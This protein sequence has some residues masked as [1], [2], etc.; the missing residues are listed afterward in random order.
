MMR[1]ALFPALALLAGLAACQQDR[2]LYVDQAYV[3][4][5]ANPAAP[6]AAYFT[7]HGGARDV[8]LRDVT[9]DAAVRAEMHDSRMDKGVM[10]MAP[11]DEVAVP[12]GKTVS[13]APGGRHLMLWSINPAVAQT[14]K[15]TLTF[16][17]SN[18]D[19]ILVDAAIQKAGA[20]MADH[21]GH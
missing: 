21:G 12:A 18:G 20:P 10:K 7:V 15:I 19:R 6:A 13:F 5:N 3:T 1:R 8:T 4:L 14:G 17:F 16:I 9:T 11:L 2:P